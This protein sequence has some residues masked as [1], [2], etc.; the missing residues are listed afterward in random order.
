M[1]IDEIELDTNYRFQAI[2]ITQFV[3]EKIK[4]VTNGIALISVKHTTCCITINEAEKGLLN[5]LI[6]QY[7][8]LFPVDFRYKHNEIDNNGHA[9]LICSLVG[10]SRTVNISH[11]KLDLGTWQRIILLEFDGPRKRKVQ[12]TVIP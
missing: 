10:N 12:V 11:G 5:D 9:H 3:E 2:D 6:E 4:S 1:L 7:I 8:R